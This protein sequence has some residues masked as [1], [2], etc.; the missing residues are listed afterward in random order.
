MFHPNSRISHCKLTVEFREINTAHIFTSSFEVLLVGMLLPAHRLRPCK[1]ISPL[2]R[3][4]QQLF[5]NKF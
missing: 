2:C 4:L 1:N 3:D 5:C